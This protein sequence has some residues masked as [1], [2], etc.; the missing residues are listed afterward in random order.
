[1]AMTPKK[2]AP[3]NFPRTRFHTEMGLI[4]RSSIVPILRSSE[5]LFMVTAGTKKIKIQGTSK[6]KFP[7]SAK[8]WSKILYSPLKTHKKRP[9]SPRKAPTIRYP[10]GEVKKER[11]SFLKIA[12]I[13]TTNRFRP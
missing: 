4:N 8:P 6:K 9:V 3:Q 13:V 11:T 12:N 7:R 2:K 1:M 10:A 5:K